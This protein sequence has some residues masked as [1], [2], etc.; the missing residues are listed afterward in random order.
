[1]AS[2]EDQSQAKTGQLARHLSDAA[3]ELAG[4][5]RQHRCEQLRRSP[6]GVVYFESGA[7]DGDGGGLVLPSFAGHPPAVRAA[8]LTQLTNAFVQRQAEEVGI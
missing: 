4:R 3:P 6:E 5:L 8:V 7:G 2:L 1:M